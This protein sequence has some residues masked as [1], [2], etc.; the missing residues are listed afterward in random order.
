[1]HVAI[2]TGFYTVLTALRR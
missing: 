1:V 2:H